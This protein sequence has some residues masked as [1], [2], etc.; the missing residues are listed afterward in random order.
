MFG[1]S[2][3]GFLMKRF[4][5]AIFFILLMAISPTFAID[6]K[7][8]TECVLIG[9]NLITQKEYDMAIECFDTAISMAEDDYMA[10]AYRAKANFYLGNYSLMIDD[11]TKSIE[12]YKNSSAYGL[13]GSAKLAMGDN[14]GAIEDTTKALILNPNYMKCYEVRARAEVNTEDFLQALKDASKAIKLRDN[15]AKSYE[16]LAYAQMGIKDYPSALESFKK[17]VELFKND[18]DRKNYKLVKKQMKLC[19][20]TIKKQN[21]N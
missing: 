13:R 3:G 7:S 8:S 17:S 9:Q 20:K 1:N 12:I 18:R 2:N 19:K 4:F 10:Y 14:A 16:V 11:T 6:C 15:Y 5:L 21:K